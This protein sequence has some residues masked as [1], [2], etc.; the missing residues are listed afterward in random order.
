M[1]AG[2]GARIAGIDAGLIH[3]TVIHEKSFKTNW[4]NA[5]RTE[6]RRHEVR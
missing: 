6:G 5:C 4:L 1:V 2:I 3:F